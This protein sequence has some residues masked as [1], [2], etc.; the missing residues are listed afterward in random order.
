MKILVTGGAGFI[1]SHLVDRLIEKGHEVIVVDNLST[2]KKENINIKAG[3]YNADITNYEELEKVFEKEKPEIIDHHAAQA[4]VTI[5]IKNPVFDAKT[6]ILGT[7][8]LL[9][10]AKKFNVKKFIYINSGGASYGEPIEIPMNENHPINPLSPYG[11]SKHTA[12]HYLQLYHK[13]YN[14]TFVALR[15]ANVYGPRQEPGGEAGVIS[16]FTDKLLKN[17]QPIIFGDGSQLRDYIYIKDV[18]DS[19]ILI[20]ENQEIKNQ[21][22]N[23]GTGITTSTQEIFDKLKKILNINI[24]PIYEKERP[25]DLKVSSI[26]PAKLMKLGWKP[27]Y[28]LEKGLKETVDYFKHV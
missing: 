7:I 10:L 17:Q 27:K 5:S 22:F 6:N 28:S 13:L 15:Y 18:V 2:G 12:E 11:I 21:E 23:V 8:N 19:N 25:G 9:E 4:S 24:K 26:N 1:A 20:I 3:F 16:I 14:L